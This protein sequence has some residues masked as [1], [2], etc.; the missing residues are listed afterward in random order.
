[1]HVIAA[2]L[3]EERG[4]QADHRAGRDQHQLGADRRARDHPVDLPPRLGDDRH[5]LDQDAEL[6]ERRVKRDREP[7][8]IR[9]FEP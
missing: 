5:R 8:S 3:G 9:Q 1:M 7:G 4:E 6:A 2:L